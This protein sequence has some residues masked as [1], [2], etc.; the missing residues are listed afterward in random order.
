M[1]QWVAALII[2]AMP[3]AVI[4]HPNYDTGMF[5]R[6]AGTKQAID[7]Y[8]AST[9]R[10]RMYEVDTEDKVYAMMRTGPHTLVIS[11]HGTPDG[12]TLSAGEGEARKLDLG[13][14]EALRE[15]ISHMPEDA[16]IYLRSGSTAKGPGSFAA[17]FKRIAGTRTVIASTSSFNDVNEHYISRYPFRLRITS[18]V[19][20]DGGHMPGKTVRLENIVGKSYPSGTMPEIDY[21]FME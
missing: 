13:D 12:I 19:D 20:I 8:L 15:A 21:T 4:L 18:K 10:V 9:H 7:T 16:T 14:M 11:G 2:A 3:Q 17:E 1:L 6:N 5:T